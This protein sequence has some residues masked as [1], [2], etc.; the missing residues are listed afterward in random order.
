MA[1]TPTTTQ[2]LSAAIPAITGLLG[3]LIG[4]VLQWWQ[5]ER[6]ADRQAKAA[7]KA[8][9]DAQ[10]TAQ[11]IAREHLALAAY[12]IALHLEAFS[13]ACAERMVHNFATG[14]T[15][16]W[17]PPTLGEYPITSWGVVGAAWH[18]RLTDFASTLNLRMRAAIKALSKK[19]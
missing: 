12:P 1:V 17:E 6:V 13:K 9:D 8:S 15:T 14:E 18:V 19:T 4:G 10:Q 5:A 3:V 2:I 11:A 7:K 16:A